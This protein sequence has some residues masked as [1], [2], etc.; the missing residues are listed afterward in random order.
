MEVHMDNDPA[1][2]GEKGGYMRGDT[3]GHLGQC[4]K[5]ISVVC[6]PL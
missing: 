6:I 4:N 1:L 2:D 3:A 5:S